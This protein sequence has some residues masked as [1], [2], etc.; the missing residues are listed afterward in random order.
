[1]SKI[2]IRPANESDNASI[3]AL[4]ALPIKGMIS[5]SFE[6]APD[7]FSGA[8]FQTDESEVLI[9]F[10]ELTDRLA[11]VVQIGYRL[12]YWEGV[13][14]K[15]RYLCDLR[16]HPDY[17]KGRSLAL[18][19]YTMKRKF[20]KTSSYGFLY[21]FSD[22][23]RF[24]GLILKRLA[25][26]KH[27]LHAKKLCAI[28][29]FM[30]GIPKTNR[31]NFP[32]NIVDKISQEQWDKFESKIQYKN[33]SS[34]LPKKLSDHQG[35]WLYKVNDKLEIEGCLQVINLS[36][37]KQTRIHAYHPMLGF[38]RPI[39][40]LYSKYFGGIQLPKAGQ[41]MEYVHVHHLHLLQNNRDDLALLLRGIQMHHSLKSFAY[42]LIGFDAKDPLLKALQDFKSK[43][44]IDGEIWWMYPLGMEEDVLHSDQITQIEVARI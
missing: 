9:C 11:A 29:S 7:Y 41:K 31:S 12:V 43:R 27:W 16:V 21:V 42:F 4:L 15:I 18:I 5:L 14:K 20:I 39:L 1:M 33:L 30:I 3:Q 38:F 22:N 35:L 40:N 6:R 25:T 23:A 28:Q 44:I 17:E 19:L 37:K 32:P 13:W 24:L 2:Q 26:N 34:P 8:Q 36:D 10:D